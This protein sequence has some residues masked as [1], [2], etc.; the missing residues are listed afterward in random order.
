MTQMIRIVWLC[1]AIYAVLFSAGC[2]SEER[3]V[4]RGERSHMTTIDYLNPESMHRNPVFSQGVSVN[5]PHRTVYV[6]GQN[7]V[8][9]EGNVVGS[10]D[11]AA[12]AEQIAR[13]LLT[14]IEAG[15][16]KPEHVVK[17]N[18][19]VIQGQ[20]VRDAMSA[21]QRVWGRM[22]NAP[23]ISVLFVAGLAHPDFLLEMDA[24][25]VVPVVD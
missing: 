1:S 4:N 16:A 9:A 5:G 18:I 21:F 7:A 25:A 6:G 12:Q 20:S 2:Q 14:V 22:P 8:D 15:G 17:W 11:V 10:G 19:Y 24:V 3:H 23:A 13:N